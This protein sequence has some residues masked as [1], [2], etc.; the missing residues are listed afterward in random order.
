[1][2]GGENFVALKLVAKPA[3]DETL[4]ELGTTAR[5][6]DDTLLAL[7]ADNQLRDSDRS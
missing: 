1:M 7:P 4:R 2:T 3:V 6:F 5:R